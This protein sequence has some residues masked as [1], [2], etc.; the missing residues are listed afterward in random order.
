[1]PLLLDV[2]TV[3]ERIAQFLRLDGAELTRKLAQVLVIWLLAWAAMHLTRLAARRIERLVDGGDDAVATRRERRGLT[4]AQLLRTV[5]GT[6]I[7][8]V[9]FLLTLNLFVEIGPLLAGAGILGLAIS[10]GAQ[11]L[12]KDFISGFFILFEDQF[13]VG[14]VIEAAGKSGVVER[15]SLRVV[16]LRDLQ[17]VLHIIP[18]GEIKVVSNKTRGWSRAVIDVGVAY[19]A[20]IDQALAVLR[21]E[22]ARFSAEPAWKGRLEGAVEVPGVESLSDSAVVIRILARTRPG[23]QWDVA[24]ELRRR[25]KKRLDAEGLEIP[26]PQ[27]KVHVKMEGSAGP[28][29]SLPTGTV[30]AAAAG[31]A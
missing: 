4:I 27:R 1:V 16:V 5:G 15:M 8:A 30:E 10:F 7:L 2:Q 29:A 13:A 17:G 31:G 25:L 20:D 21:D 11:S 24:R 3:L 12:V 18:N 22:A 19:D 23:S 9:A 14:D 28:T 6:T 26:F